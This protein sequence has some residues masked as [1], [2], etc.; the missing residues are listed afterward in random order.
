MSKKIIYQILPRLWGN[1]TG[2]NVH[3]GALETN[4]TGKFCNIDTETISYL[5][6]LGVS[7]I[8]LTGVIRHA[9]L[10]STQGCE[11]SSPDWVKGNAGSPYAIN[12]YFDVNPYLATDSEHRMEEF[13]SLVERIHDAGLKVIID[14]IPNHV[15]R[16][17]GR[18][19]E[20]DKTLRGID[21]EIQLGY[22]DDPTVHW[23]P[24]NDFF[25]YPG[26]ALVLPVPDG[27]VQ[28]WQE[29][30]A[31]ATGN[32]Y[33][34][35][36]GPNDWFETIKINY[37]DFH[38]RTWDKMAEV[39]RFWASKGVDG[40]RCDMVELVPVE[41]FR[42]AIR[43]LKSEYP[44]LLFVA[45]VYQKNLYAQYI[46]EAGFD[47]LYDKSG[48]YDSLRAILDKNLNDS[49]VPAEF[50]QSARMITQCWQNLGD[51]QPYML[52]FLENHDEQRIA[53]DFFCGKPEKA[54]AALV[55]SL[56]MNTAPFMLYCGQ[57]IGERGMDS[58]GWSGTDGRTT[59]F[60]WWSP[61]SYQ[62]LW[63]YIH[64]QGKLLKAEQDTLDLY[65]HCLNFATTNPAISNGT[66]YDLCYCNFGS[67]GFNR[68][69]H[70]AFLRDYEEETQLVACNFS[71]TPARLRLYIPEHAFQWLGL[72]ETERLNHN[73]PIEIKVPPFGANAIQLSANP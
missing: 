1:T 62:R 21:P 41:F 30:P 69:R 49:G 56:C 45:E 25:Y 72:A 51:L 57:E 46:R 7:H 68:D 2:K 6:G 65:K 9:T 32:N 71:D 39:L 3:N 13:E 58:E 17:Y 47:L 33:S 27:C 70:F 20:E 4:G 44:D 55:T 54:R 63:K 34:P 42:W 19:I 73:I 40:F 52:N 43:T 10:A 31:K 60:D 28:T 12:G 38:T 5:K 14:F 61:K 59:I 18:Y 37:C 64:G 22:G 48:L 24:E 36:P 23:S 67:D 15:A 26:K 8:W 53:S 35:A 16:D 66:F 11:P 29:M 50:W